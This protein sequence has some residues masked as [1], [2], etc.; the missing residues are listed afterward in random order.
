MSEKPYVVIGHPIPESLLIAAGH[1]L[2]CSVLL[3]KLRPLTIDVKVRHWKKGGSNGEGD[4]A[5]YLVFRL[6]IE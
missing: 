2:P 6:N 3:K 1:F 4:R 5:K